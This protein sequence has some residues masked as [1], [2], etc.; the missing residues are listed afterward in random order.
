MALRLADFIVRGEIFNTRQN[1]VHGFLQFQGTDR[2]MALNLTG[3]CDP[4]LFGRHFKFEPRKPPEPIPDGPPDETDIARLERIGLGD[5]A[6]Q[7]IGPT[8]IMTAARKVRVA[9][10]STEELL[11]RFDLG[12]P[13]PMEWKRCLYLEWWSQNGNVVIEL[14]DPIIEFVDGEP[15]PED[16]PEDLDDADDPDDDGLSITTIRINDDGEAEIVEEPFSDDEDDE[17]AG[18]EY[19]LF[20]NDLQRELD[21]QARATDW[22]LRDSVP[23]PDEAGTGDEATKDVREMELLDDLIENGEGELLG[24]IFKD[25]MKLPP[26]DSL[27]EKGAESQIKIAL[28]RM[29]MFGIALNVCHHFTWLEAYRYL[30]EHLCREERFFREMSGTQWVQHFDTAD[31]CDACRS[32]YERDEAEQL[33]ASDADLDDPDGDEPDDI[34]C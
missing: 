25:F 24:N 31:A 2:T 4:D 30:V 5:L 1:S 18:D 3:N 22:A 19:G 9:D 11:R 8:G 15:E 29:A 12:E 10:C 34:I 7:Q 6:W 23:A 16:L 21:A 13:P 17:E 33:D 14:P 27:D 28:G 32:E 26:P 20:S